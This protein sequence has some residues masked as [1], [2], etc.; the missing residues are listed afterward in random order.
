M[1]YPEPVYHGDTGLINAILEP[2][3]RTPEVRYPSGGTAHYLATGES[4]GGQFGLYRWEM[5]AAQGGPGPHFH[6]SIS[7]SFYVLSGTIQLYDGS[8]LDRWPAGR[9]PV[10]PGGRHP[11]LPERVGRRRL[12]A[13]PVRAGGTTRGLLRDDGSAGCRLAARRR[14]E[15]GLLPAPRHVL[16]VVP[17]FVV[18]RVDSLW[19][20]GI[21]PSS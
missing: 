9:F 14:R 4:T 15:D 17:L 6:R 5:A 8:A 18:G 3:G 10:R 21:I 16:E 1:S 20:S 13:H 2:A 7:E 12:D 19:P 11:C